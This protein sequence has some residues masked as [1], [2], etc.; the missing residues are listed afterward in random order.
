MYIQLG[1]AKHTPIL[2]SIE[3]VQGNHSNRMTK[4]QNDLTTRG[5]PPYEA[6]PVNR[7]RVSLS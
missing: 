4:A 1:N 5:N 2:I 6:R 3:H 7:R